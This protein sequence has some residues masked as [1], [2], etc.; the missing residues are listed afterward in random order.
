MGSTVVSAT[1]SRPQGLGCSA[2]L[3]P[4]LGVTAGTAVQRGGGHVKESGMGVKGGVLGLGDHQS[5]SNFHRRQGLNH[6]DSRLGAMKEFS[7]RG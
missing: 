2:T 3:T 4:V 7:Q 1:C 6:T 5:H